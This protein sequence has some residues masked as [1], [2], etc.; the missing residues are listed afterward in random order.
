MKKK[1]TEGGK[2]GK[3]DQLF[4][5]SSSSPSLCQSAFIKPHPTVLINKKDE[6]KE[7]GFLLAERETKPKFQLQ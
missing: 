5:L 6:K 1:R 7:T 4:A 2:E 3:P